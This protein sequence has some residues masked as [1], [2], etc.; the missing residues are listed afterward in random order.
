MQFH[1]PLRRAPRQHH[2]FGNR[3]F[4]HAARIAERRVEDSHA[5]PR[6]GI[7]VDLV[8]PDAEASD[9]H[10]LRRRFQNPLID[11]GLGTDAQDLHVGQHL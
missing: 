5:A 1:R 2:D 10:E 11:L 6:G 7:H 8:R 4:R 3:Q 9:S